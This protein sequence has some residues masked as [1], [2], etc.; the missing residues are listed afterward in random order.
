MAAFFLIRTH[1]GNHALHLF[2]D[3]HDFFSIV[4]AC[5]PFSVKLLPRCRVS[6]L[7]FDAMHQIIAGID[8]GGL[9]NRSVV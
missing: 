9:G 6:R 5:R 1:D 4:A 3:I 8:D 7:L 2:M